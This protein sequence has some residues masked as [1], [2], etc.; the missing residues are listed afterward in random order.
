ME[1]DHSECTLLYAPRGACWRH[2]SIGL[3][4][5]SEKSGNTLTPAAV[6]LHY[7]HDSYVREVAAPNGGTLNLSLLFV[8][9]FVHL[10]DCSWVI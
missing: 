6:R 2:K 1:R 9:N 4:L 3:I 8:R 5:A 10:L 7:P